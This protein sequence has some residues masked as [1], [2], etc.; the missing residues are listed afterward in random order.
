MKKN[1]IIAV[2]VVFILI[3][4][5][6]IFEKITVTTTAPIKENNISKT[7]TTTFENKI[8][9]SSV[10][11]ASATTTL[12]NARSTTTSVAL[13]WATYT[14]N[15][16]E[17]SIDYPKNFIYKENNINAVTNFSVD[18]NDKKNID[19]GEGIISVGVATV[20]SSIDDYFKQIQDGYKIDKRGEID[21]NEAVF[22]SYTGSDM[23]NYIKMV[24]IKHGNDFYTISTESFNENFREVPS[25][26]IPGFADN[27]LSESDYNRV[28]NSFK[29]LK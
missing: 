21:N 14:N 26:Y 27:F 18:F 1:I 11:K 22:Y 7:S 23:Y 13:G 12:E 6:F 9:T 25:T 29:F 4:A 20:Y 19:S 8:S 28:I 17:F 15:R 10:N 24:V 2:V 5:V 16:F 3:F